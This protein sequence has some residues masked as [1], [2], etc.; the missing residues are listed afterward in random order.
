MIDLTVYIR[1]LLFSHECVVLPSFGGFIGNYRPAGIDVATNTFTPPVKAITFNRNLN[2]NDGLLIGRISAARGIGYADS[3]RLVEE[4][5]ESL[6]KRLSKGERIV[7]EGIGWFQNNG[8]GNVRFEPD[9][10]SNYLLDSYGLTSFRRDPVEASIPGIAS[11]KRRDRESLPS[12]STRKMVWRAVIAVP[13]IAAMIFV[14]LKTDL[15]R[16]KASLNPLASTEFEENRASSARESEGISL[17]EAV[18]AEPETVP[19]IQEDQA[20]DAVVQDDLTASTVVQAERYFLIAGSFKDRENAL[21]L[22]TL[23]SGKGYEAEIFPADNGFFRV[24]LS[25][26]SS[27]EEAE[28]EM[29]RVKAD[30][31]E[32]WVLKR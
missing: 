16:G 18:S 32:I 10:D 20:V 3:K 7:M 21:K 6:R 30:F 8:E 15:F 14:P 1:E 27:H 31:P 9:N 19:V 11:L 5:V 4:F 23:A 29:G 24:S 25:S 2:T 12:Y 22:S 28:G 17:Q 13:F 26:F